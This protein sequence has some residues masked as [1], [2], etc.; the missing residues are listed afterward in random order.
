MKLERDRLCELYLNSG[1]SMP[2]IAKEL[3]VSKSNIEYW[4]KK[5]GIPR[6]P[7]L[8]YPRARF[9]GDSREKAYILGL[10]YGDLYAPRYKKG[11]AVG[12]TTTHPAMAELF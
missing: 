6:R 9:A 1:F 2:S 4:M 3:G 8:R 10:R 7:L 12:T 11:I 5:F